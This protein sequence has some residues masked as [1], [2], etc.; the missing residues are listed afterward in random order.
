VACRL[1]VKLH[2]SKVIFTDHVLRHFFFGKENI[3]LIGLNVKVRESEALA[4][5][6]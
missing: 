2:F 4:L 3:Y 6:A 5:D 1:A